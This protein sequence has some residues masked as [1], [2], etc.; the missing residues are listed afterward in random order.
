MVSDSIVAEIFAHST[1]APDKT[2]LAYEKN[3]ISYGEL[4]RKIAS[5]AGLLSDIGVAP[6]DRV[7]LT[8][9]SRPSFIYGY[10]ATHLVGS[11][12][13]PVDIQITDVNLRYIIE[14]VKPRAIFIN[15]KFEY[16]SHRTDMIDECDY[17]KPSQREYSM[18]RP[19]A[20]A[21]ILF[22]TGTTGRRKG[23]VLTHRNIL[24][25]AT[26]INTFIG[27]T[28]EDRE[29]NP[30]PL[31][32]SFG[33]GRLRCSMLAGGVTILTEGFLLP[34]RI[35]DLIECWRATGFCSV[36]A[37]WAVLFRLCGD[38]IGE[39]ANQLKYIEIGSAPMPIDEK[40]RLME[41]LP[42]TRICMHYGLTEAS[43]STFIEFHQS[44]NKLQSIGKASPNVE[45]K[46]VDEDNKERPPMQR[47]GIL[48]RADTV[49]LEYWN[50]PEQTEEIIIEGWLRTGDFGYKDEE[51]FIYL[52]GREKELLN[53]GGRKVSPAEIEEVLKK[54]QFIEDCICIGIP[55]PKGIS[56][57]VIKAYLVAKKG[58]PFKLNHGQLIDFLRGR[59]EEYKIPAVFEW[60]EALPK[61]S[62]GKIQR[63]LLK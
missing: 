32:H 29:V 34:K 11:I 20:I 26:N 45:I 50:D 18:P 38:K 23:V 14:Q 4:R 43:R 8:A 15:R 52:L 16:K 62:S 2:A 53:V 6:G 47:G 7:I 55:D 58:A 25:A 54:H 3:S 44:K 30:L 49:M 63:Q 31:S 56:G 17:I 41:L 37:G 51:G 27:N 28:S 22:T 1:M 24:A 57:E 35:F 61:T 12:A 46:I 48:V 13:V 5:A 21:D 33:L 36:P 10:F 39:Y 42:N 19:D 59:I 9:S 60:V 40:K